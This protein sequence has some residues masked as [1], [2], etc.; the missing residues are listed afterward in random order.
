MPISPVT[1][2]A[3]PKTLVDVRT[4]TGGAI[5]DPDGNTIRLGTHS[6]NLK[7]GETF[8]ASLV[9][10]DAETNP[11][12]FQYAVDLEYVDASTRQRQTWSSGWFSLT[13]SAASTWTYARPKMSGLNFPGVLFPIIDL[14]DTAGRLTTAQVQFLVNVNGW[15]VGG[16]ATTTARHT[17]PT[18][19]DPAV[20]KAELA[21]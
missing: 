19:M 9:P 12:A 15:E 6:V 18:A 4:N 21:A 7:N 10:T 13:E 20:R 16:H 17:D 5:I 14:L 11:T 2:T 3:N 1:L 8:S